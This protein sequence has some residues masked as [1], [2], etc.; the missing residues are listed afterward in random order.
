[1]TAGTGR[2]GPLTPLEQQLAGTE[3]VRPR[4]L[5]VLREAQ[6]SF[7]AGQRIDMQ[8]LAATVGVDRATLYRW[9]GSRERLLSEVLWTLLA[10]TIAGLREPATNGEQPSAADVVTGAARATMSNAGMQ[11]FLEREGELALRLLTTKASA[12]QQR[13]VDLTAEV[14][15]ADRRAGRLHSTIPAEDLPFLVVRVMESFIYL[16]LITGDEPDASRSDSVIRALL[17]QA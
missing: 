7:L 12:F 5:D 4:P 3:P 9:V 15:D 2:A 17:P 16:S 14:V 10:R 6:R 13:L 1:M 11:R 8:T